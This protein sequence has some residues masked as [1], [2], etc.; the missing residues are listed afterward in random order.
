MGKTK[1]YPILPNVTDEHYYITK[2]GVKV[3]PVFY[4]YKWYIEIDNNGTLQR[5]E[6]ALTQNEINLAIH[7]IILYCYKR[8]T[9]DN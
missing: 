1:T 8:L 3:Y 2:R 6:K 4:N 9:N 7:K 5:F